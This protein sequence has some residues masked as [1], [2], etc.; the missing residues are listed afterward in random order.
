MINVFC[1]F[2]ALGCTQVSVNDTARPAPS[3]L[4]PGVKE[5]AIPAGRT[6][7]YDYNASVPTSK[8]TSTATLTSL[9]RDGSTDEDWGSTRCNNTIDFLKSNSVTV[10][11]GALI[12]EARAW[13]CD[14]GGV[15]S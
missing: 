12:V 10:V 6:W 3:Y 15:Q 1:R 8:L 7:T 2:A 14:S 4:P 5:F 11:S 9:Y 13:R